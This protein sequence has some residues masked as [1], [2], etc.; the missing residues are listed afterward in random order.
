MTASPD[1]LERQYWADVVAVRPD[2]K[3][4]KQIADSRRF[5]DSHA[6]TI[7]LCYGNDK[8]QRLDLFSPESINQNLYYRWSK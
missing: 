4:D 7:D 1:W 3:I 6:A 2:R 8:R 5:R